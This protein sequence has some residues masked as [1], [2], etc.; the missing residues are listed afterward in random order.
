MWSLCRHKKFH[1][2]LNNFPGELYLPSASAPRPTIIRLPEQPSALK[3]IYVSGL[4]TAGT[5]GPF[6]TYLVTNSNPVQVQHI[7]YSTPRGGFTVSNTND[8]D[9]SASS[10]LGS[11]QY[12]FSSLLQNQRSRKS[13]SNSIQKATIIHEDGDEL[14]VAES[15][16]LPSN[17]NSIYQNYKEAQAKSEEESSTIEVPLS[18]IV[19]TESTEYVGNV[20]S[21][22]EAN[23]DPSSSTTIGASTY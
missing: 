3:T 2:Y 4:T 15:R 11:S 1:K 9:T 23:Q 5:G 21:S 19:S 12:Q 16:I 22:T 13:L 8:L 20:A 17:P 6:K 18:M 10:D 14:P 7:G